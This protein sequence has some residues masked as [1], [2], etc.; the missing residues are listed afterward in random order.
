[1]VTICLKRVRDLWRR[2]ASKRWQIAMIR[3]LDDIIQALLEQTA[4][5][6]LQV[7]QAEVSF[8]LLDAE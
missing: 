7:G 5:P 4:E 6:G 8:D 1:M 2:C 3:N